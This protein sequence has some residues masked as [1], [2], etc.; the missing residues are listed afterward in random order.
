MS[1]AAQVLDQLA[2]IG[3]TV[4]RDGD[5]LV[6]HASWAPVPAELVARLRAVKQEIMAEI[7]RLSPP[8]ISRANCKGHRGHRD[9]Q[10]H[11]PHPEPERA[12]WRPADWQ[13]DHARRVALRL[14][15]GHPEAVG[16]VLAWGETLTEWHKAHGVPPPAR[17]C[18]GCGQPLSGASAMEVWDG[19]CV[20]DSPAYACLIAYGRRWR[21]AAAEALAG[22]GITPPEHPAGA[23]RDYPDD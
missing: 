1:A 7:T 13:A 3:A 5:R 2:R 23:A 8:D 15:L 10:D 4:S 20:H 19:G 17:L 18:A 22:M 21:A 6:V 12:G 14:A 11:T 9:H 16:W